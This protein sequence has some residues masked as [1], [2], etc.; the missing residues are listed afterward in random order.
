MSGSLQGFRKIS[1]QFLV[2]VPASVKS[3]E[4]EASSGAVEIG[5]LSCRVRIHSKDGSVELA[6]ADG[7]VFAETSAQDIN[8]GTVG[9][10]GW[11]RT[12][13]GRISVNRV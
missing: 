11:F 3:L 1:T 13:A 2:R 6:D 9:G 4:L 8:I 7:P 10:D 12:V 5:N